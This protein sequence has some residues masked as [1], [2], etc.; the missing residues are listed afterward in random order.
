M[1]TNGGSDIII[2]VNYRI[3]QRSEQM[4]NNIPN[5]RRVLQMDGKFI[6]R[7]VVK[8]VV[9]ILTLIVAASQL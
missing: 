3:I 1:T 7:K 9:P 4:L 2:Y 5:E 6:K 8:V